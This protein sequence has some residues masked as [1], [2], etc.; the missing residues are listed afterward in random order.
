MPTPFFLRDEY[1]PIYVEFWTGNGGRN[2]EN[3]KDLKM[4]TQF[5]ASFSPAE[6]YDFGFDLTRMMY[7]DPDD[8]PDESKQV[9]AIDL[10]F[11]ASVD[12]WNGTYIDVTFPHEI[13]FTRQ[14]GDNIYLPTQEDPWADIE[15]EMIQSMDE[16]IRCRIMMN[17][18]EEFCE[19]MNTIRVLNAFEGES[20]IY[21]E[22]ENIILKPTEPPSIPPWVDPSIIPQADAINYYLDGQWVNLNDYIIVKGDRSADDID[23]N[24]DGTASLREI[25]IYFAKTGL[26]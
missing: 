11:R 13:D 25:L 5:F 14:L 3:D 19:I 7:P 24:K 16:N 17:V 6:I 2:K 21:T 12:I 4:A 9:S 10:Y 22:P 18:T 15:C 23:F 8:F 20:L 26:A 1:P